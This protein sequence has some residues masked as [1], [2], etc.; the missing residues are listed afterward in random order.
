MRAAI[1][2]TTAKGKRKLLTVLHSTVVREFPN[3]EAAK[4]YIRNRPYKFE[5][6]KVVE[7]R[8]GQKGNYWLRFINQSWT[9]RRESN[10]G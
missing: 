3:R 1:E 8:D 2:I 7:W 5:D 9:G 4:Q 6:A 10:D